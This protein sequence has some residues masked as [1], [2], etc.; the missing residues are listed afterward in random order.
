MR[1]QKKEGARRMLD[2]ESFGGVAVPDVK[3]PDR[4]D[5]LQPIGAKNLIACGDVS[6]RHLRV[7]SKKRETKE[8]PG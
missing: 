8:A 7:F 2:G 4:L 1:G 5:T 6:L 3:I